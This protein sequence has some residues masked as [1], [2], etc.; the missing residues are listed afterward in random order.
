MVARNFSKL[1]KAVDHY[2]PFSG[3]VKS[4]LYFI[5]QALN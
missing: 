5:Q 3:R 2:R 1:L 4:K